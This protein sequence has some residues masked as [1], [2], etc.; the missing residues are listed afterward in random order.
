M[1]A[2][3]RYGGHLTRAAAILWEIPALWV[4]A[5]IVAT[6]MS[7]YMARR[8]VLI[9]GY[10]AVP[11][12]KLSIVRRDKAKQLER[13]PASCRKPPQV[14]R[15]D[16]VGVAL[17]NFFGKMNSIT[18]PRALRKP[19]Y[20]AYGAPARP[21]M[22]TCVPP[23]HS[24]TH[25][26]TACA[27]WLVGVRFDE[28]KL[29][30]EQFACLQDFFTRELRAGLRPIDGARELVSPVDGRVVVCGRVEGDRLEQVKGVSYSLE[31]FLGDIEVRVGG[32]G[33]GASAEA[34]AVEGD[35]SSSEATADDSDAAPPPPAHETLLKPAPGNALFHAVIYLAPGDYHRIHSPCA[36]EV[37]ACG[38]CARSVRWMAWNCPPERRGARR[39]SACVTF[40]ARS[41]PFRPSSRG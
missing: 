22:R 28:V 33:G 9:P 29:P 14:M 10:G 20:Y 15:W 6:L 17:S 36:F 11:A 41:S 39:C 13:R 7:I 25:S 31:Q 16:L 18:L 12:R 38:L 35:D 19:V 30:L 37:R 27:G 1:R 21:R 34:R 5:E 32:G 4:V 23:A 8:W 26:R 24:L 2:A 3:R 40:R